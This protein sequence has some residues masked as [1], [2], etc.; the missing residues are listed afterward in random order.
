VIVLDN[1]I[2][3]WR[4]S[5]AGCLNIEYALL[6]FL[7]TVLNT[8]EIVMWEPD[9]WWQSAVTQARDTIDLRPATAA[10]RG[11]HRFSN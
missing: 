10:T 1:G 6:I 3:H 7:L 5:G 11:R 8:F 4:N 9:Y 2:I